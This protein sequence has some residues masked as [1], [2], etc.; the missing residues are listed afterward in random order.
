MN[1]PHLTS[2]SL[3]DGPPPSSP[4]DCLLIF[5]LVSVL[6][7][8]HRTLSWQFKVRGERP[9]LFFPLCPNEMAPQTKPLPISLVFQ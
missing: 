1:E 3:T 2:A 9:F 8:I 5:E 4:A 7:G 6:K